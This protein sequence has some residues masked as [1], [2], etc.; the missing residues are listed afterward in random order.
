MPNWPV[1]AHPSLHSTPFS[2]FPFYLYPLSTLLYRPP[3]LPFHFIPFVPT[4]PS[5]CLCLRWMQFHIENIITLIN[6]YDVTGFFFN[7]YILMIN[8]MIQNSVGPG[9]AP[10]SCFFQSSRI[11][12]SHG[13]PINSN[14]KYS[15]RCD[16]APSSTIS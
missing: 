2:S 7:C 1:A 16:A 3:P 13:V 10:R 9:I 4:S 11:S 12:S 6:I 15:I 5:Q 8:I 14:A